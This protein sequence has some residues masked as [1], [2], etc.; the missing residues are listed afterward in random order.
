MSRNGSGVKPAS[1]SSIQI[2]FQYQG[3]RCRENIQLKP[4]PANLKRVEKQRAAIIHAIDQGTF[5]YANYFPDSPRAKMFFT[6]SGQTEHVEEYLTKWLRSQKPVLKASSYEG[7]RKIIDN[8]VIPQFG[9]LL[10]PQWRRK[11]TRDWLEAMQCGNKRLANIQSV[12]RKALSDA[13][14]DELLDVNFMTDFCYQR[15]AQIKEEE[16]IDPFTIEEQQSILAKCTQ[17]MANQIKFSFWTGV[18]TSELIALNWGDVDFV[19]GYIRIRRAMTQASKGQ[20]ETTKTASGLREIKILKPTL[21]AL[22]AQRPHTFLKGDPIFLNPGTGQRWTGDQQIRDAWIRILKA[23]GVRY[24]WP[25]QTRHTYASM[26]VSAG[27]HPMWVA[28][29][30]GHRDWTMIAKIYAKWMPEADENAG[31]KAESIFGTGYAYNS[32]PN[33]CRG[34]CNSVRKRVSL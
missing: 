6:T 8:L 7:Y 19:R 29:Q 21:E 22:Q 15:K 23:A 26:M 18:R 16:D 25:Y 33:K 31:Q 32:T 3:F 30:M 4:T 34:M 28:K 13:V 1:K 24:R 20:A 12:I 14:D 17:D 11:D 10:L 27:E 2:T 9:H 5:E